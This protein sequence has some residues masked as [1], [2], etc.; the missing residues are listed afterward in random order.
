MIKIIITAILMNIIVIKALKPLSWRITDA[1]TKRTTCEPG[2][3]VDDSEEEEE[4]E[5]V[6]DDA[7]VI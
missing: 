6:D 7:G 1:G 3:E 5:D 2:E 4:D